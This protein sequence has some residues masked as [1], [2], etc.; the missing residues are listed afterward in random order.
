M[1]AMSPYMDA[2]PPFMGAMACRWMASSARKSETQDHAVSVAFGPGAELVYACT[3]L[4]HLDVHG[5]GGA[6]AEALGVTGG[7][8]GKG[9][10]LRGQLE[11]V[12]RYCRRR[13]TA[14]VKTVVLVK[15]SD[16]GMQE[17]DDSDMFDMR[18][19]RF[20]PSTQRDCRQ[21]GDTLATT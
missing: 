3:A 19:F 8:L 6:A 13:V 14:A 7:L 20:F 12:R 2:M 17:C 5:P 9:F 4:A 1:G 15:E 11:K 10:N 18:H 16:E 21:H